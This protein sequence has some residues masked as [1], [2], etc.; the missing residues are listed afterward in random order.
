MRLG[1]EVAGKERIHQDLHVGCLCGIH[2]D[3]QRRQLGGLEEQQLVE[4][5]DLLTVERTLARRLPV[6]HDD[7]AEAASVR[8]RHAH[9]ASP[10]R[11]QPL[12]PHH[13]PLGHPYPAVRTPSR[14]T[15]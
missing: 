2:A 3:L 14:R 12:N 13:L 5:R 1:A 11:A 10:R 4:D 9:H 8:H 15:R 7:L 6:M